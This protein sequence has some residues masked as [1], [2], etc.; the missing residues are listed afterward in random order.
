MKALNILIKVYVAIFILLA[1]VSCETRND[2]F[3]KFNQVP[4]IY[5]NTQAR[6]FDDK[7]SDTQVILRHGEQRV[8]YFDYTDDYI[9]NGMDVKHMVFSEQSV[10]EYIKCSIDN[11]ARKLIIEDT[12][13]QNTLNDRVVKMTIKIVVTDYYGDSGE[14]V[15]NITDYDDNPPIPVISVTQIQA[16]EYSISA[17]GTTDSDSDEVV[18]YEY[19]IDGEPTIMKSGYENQDNPKDLLNPGM[20]GI[21][22]TYIISTPLN[23]VKHAFQTSGTHVIYVRA[24]DS[25][26][27]WSKW[28]R[29]NIDI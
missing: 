14:A 13:P 1:V 28:S 20:A 25:L 8:V 22:G 15:I 17:V 29:I 21:K 12:L 24:K 6:K 18:A 9:Q 5:V 3:H 27:L 19:L 11:D 4:T 2:L 23:V 10:P 16:M 7:K 26:G